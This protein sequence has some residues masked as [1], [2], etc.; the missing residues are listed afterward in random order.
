MTTLPACRHRGELATPGVHHCLSP[1]L[2]GLKLVTADTCGACYC[3][4]H[5]PVAARHVRLQPCLRLGREIDPASPGGLPLLECH[6]ADHPRTTEAACQTCPDY[7]FP[8]FTPQT[9]PAAVGPMLDLPP[10]PQVDG[11]WHWPNVQEGFRLAAARAA[12]DTPPDATAFAGRGVV[13]VGGGKY[14]ASA[15]VTARVL[16]RVGCK[17]PIQLWHLAG[18]VTAP[19]R[20]ALAPLGVECVDADELATRRP[21]RFMAGGVWKGWQLKPYSVMNSPFREVLYLDADCYPT[22]DPEYLFDWAPYRERGAVFWPDLPVSDWALTPEKWQVFGVPPGWVPIESG[23]FIV[24]KEACRRE[25]HL[26]LWYNARADYVYNIL[27]GDKDT[28]NIAW[29]QLGTY[30][31]MTQPRPAWDTH[32]FLHYGPAGEVV[33]QHRCRDKFRLGGEKYDNTP[34]HAGDNVFNP[35]LA[36]EDECFQFLADLRDL[37]G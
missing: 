30:Y 37:M 21:Y 18:E 23:Q 1:K 15:Y 9:P 13:I 29:R 5:A 31:A 28:F 6:H 35:N 27:Y 17:L 24:N 34:Q 4:D 11:W 16:R 25:L 36:L 10:R 3:R 33:F 8:L 26:A 22:R 20:A 19:M 14:F 12:A 2:I 32:T 7:L